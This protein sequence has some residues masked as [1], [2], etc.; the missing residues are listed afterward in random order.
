MS[1]ENVYGFAGPQGS[2]ALRSEAAPTTA[3]DQL[4]EELEVVSW[5]SGDAGFNFVAQRFKLEISR[6]NPDHETVR[7]CW[8]ALRAALVF[9]GAWGLVERIESLLRAMPLGEWTR[10]DRP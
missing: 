2:V 6:P 9:N 10:E 5:S 3:L 8:K 4:L 1:N 7:K